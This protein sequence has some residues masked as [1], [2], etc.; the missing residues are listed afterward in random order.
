MRHNAKELSHA[1]PRLHQCFMWRPIRH[2][3]QLSCVQHRPRTEDVSQMF[4]STVPVDDS[5]YG[6]VDH[7]IVY[8]ACVGCI[9]CHVDSSLVYISIDEFSTSPMMFM[10]RRKCHGGGD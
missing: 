3:N 8:A 9:G 2:P 4:A 7:G 1:T 10:S 6:M 5:R